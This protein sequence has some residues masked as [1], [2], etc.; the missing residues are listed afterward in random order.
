MSAAK[1]MA[2]HERVQ[3]YYLQTGGELTPRQSRRMW[4]KFSRAT[5]MP[6]DRRRGKARG[7]PRQ[8][9]RSTP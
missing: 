5:G 9:K 7:T 1:P 3:N 6:A 4:H 8:R 2:M